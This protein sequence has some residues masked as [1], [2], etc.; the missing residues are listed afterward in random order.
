MGGASGRGGSAD[1]APTVNM[2]VAA[3]TK[4]SDVKQPIHSMMPPPV[5]Q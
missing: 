3:V 5:E 2:A 1:A 4:A